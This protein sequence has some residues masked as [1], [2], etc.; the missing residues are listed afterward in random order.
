L[1]D[2][3]DNSND[4]A[5]VARQY[6][7][8]EI[9][10]DEAIYGKGAKRGLPADEEELFAHLARKIQA[11]HFLTQRLD[12]ELHEKDQAKLFYDMELP[13][14]FILADM[15]IAGITVDPTRL[16]SMKGEFSKR[17]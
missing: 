9:Q 16:Q 7:Y 6:G 3:N 11:I 8:T 5:S 13:L 4:I 10:T 17:L 14:S 15:E 12:A 1:L 2:T